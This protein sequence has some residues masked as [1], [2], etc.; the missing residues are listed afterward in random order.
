MLGT[1]PLTDRLLEAP[2]QWEA[3]MWTHIAGHSQEEG[4]PTLLLNPILSSDRSKVPTGPPDQLY[5]GEV[6]GSGAHREFGVYMV[7]KLEL[8]PFRLVFTPQ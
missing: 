8:L 5:R 3:L 4:S 1:H 2:P 6:T 7:W